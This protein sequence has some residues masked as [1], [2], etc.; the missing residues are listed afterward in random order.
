[1]QTGNIVIGGPSKAIP[2]PILGSRDEAKPLEMAG[3]GD[4]KK[5]FEK[6]CGLWYKNILCEQLS[7][8][9]FDI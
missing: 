6:A 2:L 1:M 5:S 3:G 4:L 7:N 8:A 9:C